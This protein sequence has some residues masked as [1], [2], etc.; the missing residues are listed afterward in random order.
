[1]YECSV[2]VGMKVTFHPKVFEAPYTPHYDSYKDRI[3]EVVSIHPGQHIELK[4][5]DD[6]SFI[7]KG[8]P[9]DDELVP[10]PF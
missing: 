3:F 6:L 8:C 1:M 10:I 4:C 5:V 9:H 2:K 7:M